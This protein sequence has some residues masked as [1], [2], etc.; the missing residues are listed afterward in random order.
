MIWTKNKKREIIEDWIKNK[1]DEQERKSINKIKSLNTT[2][3]AR[4]ILMH[5]TS[6]YKK[7]C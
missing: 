4:I 3:K 7:K 2:L 5:R 1:K 6:F